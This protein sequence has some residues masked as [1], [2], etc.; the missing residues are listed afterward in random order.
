MLCRGLR[1][2]PERTSQTGLI[3]VVWYTVVNDLIQ[4]YTG[5]ARGIRMKDCRGVPPVRQRDGAGRIRRY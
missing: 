5:G 1:P 4:N 2:N 3:V